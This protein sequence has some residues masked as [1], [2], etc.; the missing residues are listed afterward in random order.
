LNGS[1]EMFALIL[2]TGARLSTG[3]A[4]KSARLLPEIA[5]SSSGID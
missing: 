3:T 1:D 4:S 5:R 2:L